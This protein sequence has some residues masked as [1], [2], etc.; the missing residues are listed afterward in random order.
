[1]CAAGL[2]NRTY[3]ISSHC[4]IVSKSSVSIFFQ[5]V[6]GTNLL[7]DVTAKPKKPNLYA[8]Q[9]LSILFTDEEIRNGCVEPRDAN[10]K[11]DVLD[12]EKINL[13]KSRLHKHFVTIYSTKI[14]HI[15]TV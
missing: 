11:K 10:G 5:N 1:M 3:Q 8:T 13:I 9:L 4:F 14:L 7:T 15:S 2:K 6:D 12:Q